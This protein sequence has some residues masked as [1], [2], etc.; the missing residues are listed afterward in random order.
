VPPERRVW[1]DGLLHRR[2]LPLTDAPEP[3]REG[4]AWSLPHW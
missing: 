1:G 3:M 2:D 4:R